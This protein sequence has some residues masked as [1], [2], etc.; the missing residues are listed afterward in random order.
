MGS[1]SSTIKHQLNNETLQTFSPRKS[2]NHKLKKQ[3]TVDIELE[4]VIGLYRSSAKRRNQKINPKIMKSLSTKWGKI[5]PPETPGIRRPSLAETQN[6]SKPISS[7]TKIA[8]SQSLKKN[9]YKIK[10][11]KPSEDRGLDQE[12]HSQNTLL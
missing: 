1:A 2:H 12:I 8:I 5:L 6:T 11:T 7:Q 9:K 4:N 10:F 3:V